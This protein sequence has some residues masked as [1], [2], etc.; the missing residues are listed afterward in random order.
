MRTIGRWLAA[1]TAAALV[2]IAAEVPMKTHSASAVGADYSLE[3]SS[4]QAGHTAALAKDG[5]MGTLW[6]AQGSAASLIC[7]LGEIRSVH[8]YKQYFDK[9][10]VWYFCVYGSADGDSWATLADYTGGA[11]GRVFSDSVTGFYRYLRLDIVGSSDG[12]PA[13]SEE[14]TVA[15]SPLSAG[16]NIAL[17]MKG[18]SGSWVAGF[19]H[20]SAFDGDTG[21]YYCANDGSY[22][23]HCGV[24]WE[25]G[26][27][28]KSVAVR[29]QDYGAFDFEIKAKDLSGGQVTLVSR[30]VRT[31]TY[32]TFETD[33]VYSEIE[34]CVY[35]GPGWA[36]LA[37]ME[38]Y[39]FRNLASPLCSDAAETRTEQDGTVYA[40]GC[41]A[42]VDRVDAS[43]TVYASDDGSDWK[44]FHAPATVRYLKTG[45]PATAV[46]ASKLE[47]DLA[48]GLKGAV[49]DYSNEQF[50]AD[51]CTM[52]PEHE[53]GRN[54][55]WCAATYNGEHWLRLD[56]GRACLIEKVVQKFQDPGSYRYK[57]E[58]SLDG[59]TWTALADTYG[60]PQVGQTFTAVTGTQK[61]WRY[62]RLSL[63]DCGW[64]NSNR[65]SVVG[66]GSPLAENWW[67]RESGVVRY[68]P[69]KQGNVIGDIISKLDTFRESG[70]KVLE[71]H[72]PYEGKG[73]IWA[74]LGA[75]NNYQA[76]P[77]NGT[78]D[79][80]ARLLDEAHKRDMYVFMFGNVGYARVSSEFF[81]K[82]CTDYANGVHSQE[83][84]WFLF[85][86]TCPDPS[87]WFWSDIA[88]AYYYAYWGEGGEVPN[89]NFDTEAWRKECTDYLTFW[90]DFGF[91]GIALDA[92]LAY[93]FGTTDPAQATYNSITHPLGKYNIMMLPEGTGDYNY[94][95]SYHYTAIQNYNMGNWGGGAW[96]L[97]ID[98]VTDHNARTVDDLIK[99]GRDN[100][101]SL[102]GVTIA[103]LSFEQKYEHVEDYKRAAEAALLCTSGHMAF[104]HSGTDVFIGQDIMET[105]SEELRSEVK[106]L[107]K[108]Q[109]SWAG[110]NAGGMRYRVPTNDDTV[111]Y[112]YCKADATG[113]VKSVCVFNYS[114][115]RA[116]ITVD[117][118]NTGYGERLT[119]LLM[120]KQYTLQGGKLTVTLGSGE[121][122]I[123][124]EF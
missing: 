69:K 103:P 119:D 101:V 50:S 4:E 29:M 96:S 14:F 68:Y 82:A 109:N 17:G 41:P 35:A 113:N 64:A 47:R 1:L 53:D 85:S 58:V 32:F 31:G 98:A 38:V 34:Y 106:R 78:L 112:A 74:G 114:A 10:N 23:Q 91:D 122:L 88:G 3:A 12:S 67:Q 45:T 56:L 55:Y 123:L 72:Q 27:R 15:S 22:P 118:T 51:K 111:H 13:N 25:Y 60:S 121:Y 76:D 54:W 43:G 110:F 49:S 81:R 18:Y 83:R 16:T 108:L 84:D 70:F 59:K 48:F 77:A 92:P 11:A 107:F 46:W 90:A 30:A 116:T 6:Q 79:D 36:S 26:V 20:E 42:Y 8:S 75:T 39:G 33:G 86:D 52:H 57:I 66:Y 95:Y 62:V 65:L 73:D 63:L 94:I 71:I 100:A 104:L 117:L 93:Y 102:G 97:G 2:C 120:G 115:D 105:W 9:E 28:A 7:D 37:E 44:E 19:E 124:G 40:F 21:S 99:S 80:W 89:Y 24:R 5:D 61:L 87:K